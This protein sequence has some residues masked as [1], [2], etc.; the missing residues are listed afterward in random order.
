MNQSRTPETSIALA[1]RESR[2]L[3][4]EEGYTNYLIAVGKDTESKMDFEVYEVT[5]WDC[6]EANTPLEADLYMTGTIKWDGC[7]HVWFGEKD[8][9][10][11]QDGYLHLCGKSY[12]NRHVEVMNAVYAL[13]EKIIARY[14]QKI[15]A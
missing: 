12:W 10:G 6:D 9:N 4:R 1:G 2:V 8:E 7:S 5:A 13:A 11:K 15:G 3:L 14:D